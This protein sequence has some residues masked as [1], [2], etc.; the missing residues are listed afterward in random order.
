ML[1]QHYRCIP[2]YLVL[3]SITLV[4]GIWTQVLL[5]A[6][7]SLLHPTPAVSLVLRVSFVSIIGGFKGLLK[8]LGFTGWELECLNKALLSVSLLVE[9]LSLR[10]EFSF[11]TIS[12]S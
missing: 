8:E 12:G 3:F 11:L 5:V 10:L 7:L 2:L 1:P 4:M 6:E 9:F